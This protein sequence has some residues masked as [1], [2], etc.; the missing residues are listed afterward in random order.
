[1][2]IPIFDADQHYYE[3][4]DCFTRYA[5]KRMAATK[6][7]KWVTEADGKRKR[8][9][10]GGQV[11]NTIGNPTFTP[12]AK[13]GAFH[14]A[15]KDLHKGGAA[16]PTAWGDYGELAPIDPTYRDREVRLTTMTNQGVER[17]LLFPTL[18]VTMEGYLDDDVDVLYDAFHAFNMWLQD[19]WGFA[20]RDRIYAAPYIPLLD[21]DRAVAELDWA[22]TEGAR[23]ITLRPGAAYGRSPADPHFDPFWS[24]VD[25]A[26]VLVTYHVLDGP[27][28]ATRAF[29]QQWAAPPR[30]YR[31][32]DFLLER[33]IAFGDNE[34]MDTLSALILHNLFGRFPNI[35]V[36]TIELG[37]TWT[38]YFLKRLQKAT[39]LMGGRKLTAFGQP[40]HDRPDAIFREQVYVSPWPEEDIV[41][42][43]K[44][45]GVDHVL[46][47]S[48]WPHPESSP[49][50]REYQDALKDLDER[51][52]RRI[53]H[54]NTFE[55]VA[56]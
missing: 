40:L 41:G 50:P 10:V 12:I 21:V 45:I 39:A 35:R 56:A 8:L 13:P 53:M 20:Y 7:V 18:G 52:V 3:S 1:M 55:L 30:P 37:S 42:L 48:D 14:M 5:S 29:R 36:A 31:M 11:F 34:V 33:T 4:E 51:S 16:N 28:L 38:P 6:F 23:V 15:L 47:G 43:T 25:E 27:S 26:G 24:R 22:L 49:Q 46:M 44:L 19:D 9:L 17:I 2:D 32:E 54:D